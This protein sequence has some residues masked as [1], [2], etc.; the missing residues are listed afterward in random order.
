MSGVQIDEDGTMMLETPP[1]SLAFHV[2]W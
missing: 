1:N 2:N